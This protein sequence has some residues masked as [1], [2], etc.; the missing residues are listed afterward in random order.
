MPKGQ[1]PKQTAASMRTEVKKLYK[2]IDAQDEKIEAST[3]LK[4]K[5]KLQNMTGLGG[6]ER[7]TLLNRIEKIEKITTTK[8]H[9]NATAKG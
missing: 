7:K 1:A 5:R 4:I 2:R 3:L 6:G 9:Q 8:K